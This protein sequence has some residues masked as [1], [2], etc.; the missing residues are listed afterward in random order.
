MKLE[1]KKLM[2][3]L[4]LNSVLLLTLYFVGV[5]A[6]SIPMEIVYVVAGT[7]LGLYYVIYNKGF[8]RRGVTPEMLP[9]TMSA[10]EKQALIEDGKRR[11]EKSRWVLTLLVPLLLTLSIDLM[12]MFVFPLMGGLF[13]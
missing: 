7:A 5:Y 13:S 10:A 3:L 4:L 12:I 6:F 8:T 2:L 1:K 11:M 9:V